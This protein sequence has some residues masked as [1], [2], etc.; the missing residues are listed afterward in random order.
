MLD[1][2]VTQ[3]KRLDLTDNYIGPGGAFTTFL[4]QLQHLTSLEELILSNNPLTPECV[5]RLCDVI[6]CLPS[7]R[8]VRLISCNIHAMSAR[9]L[10]RL[11]S[12]CD[13]LD[14]IDLSNGVNSKFTNDFPPKYMDKLRSICSRRR[15]ADAPNQIQRY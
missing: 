4:M 1:T 11:A 14:E 8:T 2:A 6:R 12:C 3:L 15:A 9:Y 5:K 10:V 13:N 7:L